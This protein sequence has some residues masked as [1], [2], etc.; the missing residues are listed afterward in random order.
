MGNIWCIQVFTSLIIN[1]FGSRLE[2]VQ[3]GVVD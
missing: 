1:F 2:N 3:G